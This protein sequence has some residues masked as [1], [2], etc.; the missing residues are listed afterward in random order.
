MD[1]VASFRIT[2]DTSGWEEVIEERLK[3]GQHAVVRFETPWLSPQQL[4]D[5]IGIS[6]P[7]IMRWIKS[8]RIATTRYGVN[9]RITLVEAERFRAWYIRDTIESNADDMLADLLGDQA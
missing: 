1:T 3:A 9:H 6:R 2:P 8:G 5:R 7:A 4:A